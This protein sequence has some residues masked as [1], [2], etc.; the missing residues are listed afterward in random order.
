M[1]N[2]LEMYVRRDARFE[3]LMIFWC[4]GTIVF[5]L[6]RPKIYIKTQGLHL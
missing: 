6:L 1:T 3:G 2:N 4:D 5:L